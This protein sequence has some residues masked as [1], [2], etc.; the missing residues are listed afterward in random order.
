MLHIAGIVDHHG[1]G[2]RRDGYL[3][4]AQVAALLA[5]GEPVQDDMPGLQKPDP[6]AD[7]RKCAG[8]STDG[9]PS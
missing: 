8:W 5:S 4:T 3:E 9:G 7:E 6:I 2:Q 1:W